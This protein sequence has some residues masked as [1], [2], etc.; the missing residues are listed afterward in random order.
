MG[1]NI[2]WHRTHCARMDQGGCSLLVG[3]QE[4]RVV[5]VKGDPDGYLNQGYICAKGR[6]LPQRL[7]H[8]ERLLYPRRRLGPR[9]QGRWERISWEEALETIAGQLQQTKDSCGARSV[10]F[11]SG[12]PKGLDHFALIRLANTFGTPNMV[13]VQ[14]VCHMP[15]ELTGRLTCGFYP[16]PDYQHPSDLILLWGSNP[17]NTNEEGCI[18][19]MVL[20]RLKQGAGLLVVDPWRTQL[21]SRADLFLQPRPG[22]D[23]ELALGML[24]VILQEGLFDRGFVENW[25]HGFE[26]LQEHCR[27]FPLQRV[28]E[29][30]GVSQELITKAARMYAQ[31]QPAALGWGNALEQSTDNFACI[32]ALICLMAVCGNLDQP[33]GNIWAQDPKIAKLKDFVHLDLLPQKKDQ[34][35]HAGQTL[36]GMATVPPAFF[37]RSVTEGVPYQVRAAYMQ[38]TNPMLSWADSNWTYQA[39]QQLDFLA[40]S[41]IFPTPSSELADIVLPAAVNPEFNDIGHFGLGHGY[42]LAR[43]QVVDPPGECRPDLWIVNQLGQR[44]AD[45]QYWPD[46]E[47]DLLQEVLAPSGLS[48]AEFAAQGLLVGESGF[49]KYKDQGFPTPS[50]KVELSLS[51]AKKL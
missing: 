37:R 43:P 46:S 36:P 27:A 21:A 14:D 10:A 45:R 9:G 5:R 15:R 34:V 3:V 7:Y 32:R 1:Q 49:R 13:G 39:L 48:Y 28:Q 20:K 30:T 50:G 6:S 47:Q 12:M 24:S 2:Q 25:T 4:G 40:V 44:L 35:L 42:I 33:G 23:A 22:T 16:V 26:E 41:E 11:C 31:A 38:S 18:C 29:I 8:P 19:K 51:K 17:L